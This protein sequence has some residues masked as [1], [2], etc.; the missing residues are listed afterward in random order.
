MTMIHIVIRHKRALLLSTLIVG[1]GILLFVFL[2]VR[3][4]SVTGYLSYHLVKDPERNIPGGNVIVSPADGIVLYVR[5][6]EKGTIPEVVK[7]DVP[8]PIIEHLKTDPPQSLESGYLV[9]VYMNTH[10]VHLV[11]IPISGV[12]RKHTVFNGP[13]MDMTVAEIRII[14]TQMIPGL[15]TLRK[16]FGFMPYDIEDEADYVLQSARDTTIIYDKRG[17]YVYLVR[18]AD[19]YVGKLLT[20]MKEGSSVQTGQKYGYITWGSQVDIFFESSQGIDIRVKEGDIVYGG[21]TVLATY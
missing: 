9:G 2:L 21:E 15:V 11:R 14:L 18:I 4:A 3:F 1:V 19:Y 20:W 12:I 7:K 5:K 16:L 17:K 6:V 8:V 10:G 13:H